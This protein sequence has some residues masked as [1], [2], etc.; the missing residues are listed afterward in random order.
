MLEHGWPALYA[1]FVWWFSTGVVIYLDGLPVRTFRWSMLGATVVLG[2]GFYGLAASRTDPS[3]WGAYVAFTSGLAIW[4]WLE[5]SFYMGWVTG[6]R[7]HPCEPGCRGWRHFGHAILCS[8]YHELAILVAAAV[9]IALTWG[10]ANPIGAW[11]FLVLWWMHQ[12]ARINVFLGV[13][14]LSEEFVP[15]HLPFLRSFL[16]R[17]P[18]NLLFPVSVTVSSVIATYL[19]E[20]AIAAEATPFE[21]A[22]LTFV[23]T[24]MVLAILEHWFLV[25]P[26]PSA[27][28]WHWSLAS[29][30]AEPGSNE[31]AA[32]D[33]RGD[34]LD[35]I[36]AAAGGL[37]TLPAGRSER[38]PAALDDQS[39]AA[40]GAST[41]V[42]QRGLTR[43]WRQ[44]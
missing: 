21:A 18:M 3:I 13:P 44:A 2:L 6:P 9:V 12:S 27:K 14:N 39:Q 16:N 34:D 20:A 29:R 19:V 30:S 11:T 28:L 41:V 37:I 43:T 22:G 5:M 42:L 26:L 7:R 32:T 23:A 1:L 25:V 8:L 10:A 35:H 4:A 24:L 38:R 17:Q 31:A 33:G 40:A 36:A 15:D